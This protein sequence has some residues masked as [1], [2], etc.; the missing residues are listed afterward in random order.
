MINACGEGDFASFA[1]SLTQ[2]NRR[3]GELFAGQQGGP[4][5]GPR[6]AAIIDRLRDAGVIGYGQ[7]SWGPTVFAVCQSEDQANQLATR[8]GPD[9]KTEIVAPIFTGATIED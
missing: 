7:S 4:Y 5:N 8:I 2:F 6:V 9:L 1:K 3:S